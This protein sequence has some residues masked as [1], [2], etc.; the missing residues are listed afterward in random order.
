MNRFLMGMKENMSVSV[1]TRVGSLLKDRLSKNLKN[2]LLSKW[3]V[4]TG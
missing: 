2:S 3:V 1:Y 4:N